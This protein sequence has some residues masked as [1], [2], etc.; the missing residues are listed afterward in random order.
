VTRRAATLELK[1][2]RLITRSAELRA[3]LERDGRD[4]ALRF[5]VADRVLGIARAGPVRALLFGGAA[6]SV[7]LWRPRRLVRLASRALLFWPVVRPFLPSL[8]RLWRDPPT[9]VP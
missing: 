4:L 2:A 7:F 9:R 6:L 5:G 3:E 8:V 1:R